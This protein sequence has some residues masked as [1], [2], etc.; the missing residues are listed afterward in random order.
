MGGREWEVGRGGSG[1]GGQGGVVGAHGRR[2]WGELELAR[3]FF[4]F[5]STPPFR[6]PAPPHVP[7]SWV[8]EKR[9]LCSTPRSR[10]S[11]ANADES[12]EHTQARARE[13]RTPKLIPGWGGARRANQMCEI[14]FRGGHGRGVRIRPNLIYGRRPAN[15][16]FREL[17][18]SFPEYVFTR[19]RMA[20]NLTKGLRERK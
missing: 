16:D 3:S 8:K 7:S 18:Y 20:R 10:E 6:V 14:N 5:S 17:F 12:N 1:G 4:P 9:A 13:P 15:R 19:E 2:R 11:G